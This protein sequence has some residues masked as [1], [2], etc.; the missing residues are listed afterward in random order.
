[1]T[2]DRL[3]DGR[4]IPTESLAIVASCA[5]DAERKANDIHSVDAKTPP[6]HHHF[7]DSTRQSLNRTT[8]Q[9]PGDTEQ[10]TERSVKN[11]TGPVQNDNS[12][13]K[14]EKRILFSDD[15]STIPGRCEGRKVSLANGRGTLE[16]LSGT[17]SPC[18]PSEIKGQ[19]ANCESLKAG[20][21]NCSVFFFNDISMLSANRTMKTPPCALKTTNCFVNFQFWL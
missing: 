1:M 10:T 15:F 2:T 11:P 20:S 4:R 8:E 21:C 12:S 7:G 16:I 6:K 9:G 13:N 5:S 17:F 3:C 14:T 18:S 19:V